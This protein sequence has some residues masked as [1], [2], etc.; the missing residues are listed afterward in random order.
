MSETKVLYLD[1]FS[2][3][4]GDMFLSAIL[5]CGY[6]LEDLKEE[7]AKL[8]VR[9][10]RLSKRIVKR[11]G[12]RAT[13]LDIDVSRAPRF[14]GLREMEHL[15]RKSAL[16]GGLKS[17]A[18]AVLS[19]LAG[20]E[21]KVHGTTKSRVHFHELGDFDT[22]LDIVGTLAG[23]ERLGVEKIYVSPLPLGRG[24]IESD[25]GPLAAPAPATLEILRGVPVRIT[26]KSGELTT[27]TGAALVRT[28]ADGFTDVISLT[29]QRIGYGAGTRTSGDTPNLLRALLG[30]E[31]SPAWFERVHVIETNIDDMDP[32]IYPYLLGKLLAAGAHDAFLTPVQMK[33]GR[34]GALI[35]VISGEKALDALTGIL[36]SETTSIGLRY[37]E[38][39]RRIRE[40]KVKWVKT[41]LGKVRVKE[42]EL[43]GP[44][45]RMKIEFE[46]LAR[47]AG[48]TG[49]SIIDIE[50]VLQRELDLTPHAPSRIFHEEKTG[51]RRWQD[52]RK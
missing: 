33:K 39:R 21:A 47:L 50:R 12:M 26:G 48:K 10:W 20:A 49:R 1:A 31:S 29:V 22:L 30:T 25:H 11:Q 32:Q 46:D 51:E 40:R 42:V 24:R 27:P 36:L 44:T 35:T 13:M 45:V 18:S 3:V 9:G 43:P 19:C 28:L 17:K 41:S 34:P 52:R 7:L 5:D 37:W 14:P 15:I 2:G 38:V 23:L 4:S 6:R 16:S 8:G